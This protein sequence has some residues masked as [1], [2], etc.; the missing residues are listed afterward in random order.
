MQNSKTTVLVTGGTGY[1]GSHTVVKLIESGVNVVILD[2]LSN[3]KFEVINRIE[4][5]T[6]YRP[7]FEVGDIRDRNK[8][9]ELF[10]RDSFD[11]VIHFAG[12][13]AVGE[14]VMNPLKYYDNNVNG[15]LVLFE[16]MLRAGVKTLVYS[17]SATVYGNPTKVPVREDFP[18]G[19][20]N[21]YGQSKLMIET[22][23]RDVY[24]ADPEWSIACLR[25]FNPVGA[26]VSGLIGEDPS[27]IPNNLFPFVG[28]V[29]IGS[30][31]KLSVFGGDY[32]TSD[33]TGVRDYIHVDDLASGHIA[34]L[35][36]L[37]RTGLLTLN[38]GSG[39]G[40]SVLEVIKA[41][42]VASGK[43]VPFE[44]VERRQGD[45]AVCYAD[46]TL[47]K[48]LLGWTTQFDIVRMCED[49][50]RWQTMN[51]KGFLD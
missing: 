8:L 20:T 27:G 39:K 15:S 23:L 16:E 48:K 3:S 45:I 42:E 21:P 4:K 7:R 10:L 36:A 19:A 35:S 43:T 11:A 12:L 40:Y 50:W 26:H 47:A 31:K 22:V 17:S 33:G 25:Y 2:N 29:A 37:Q 41:F 6:N 28:R 44:I 32:P 9:R 46:P 1:I 30:Y 24:K 14:S 18:L 5:I 34:A 51:P 49:A 13:K 38:L